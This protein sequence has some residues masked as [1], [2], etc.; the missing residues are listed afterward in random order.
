MNDLKIRLLVLKAVILLAAM[1]VLVVASS[2]V[3]FAVTPFTITSGGVGYYNI[4]LCDNAT[5]VE[6][7][8]ANELQTYIY[9]VTGVTLA[10]VGESGAQD[11]S[12]MVG[13]TAF[14]IANG[15]NPTGSEQWAIKNVGNKIIVTGGRTRGTLYAVYHLLEDEIGVRWWNLKEEYVPNLPT[16]TISNPID[17]SGTPAFGYRC[18]FDATTDIGQNTT[19]PQKD[20]LFFVRNRLNGGFGEIPAEYGGSVSFGL[21]S[22]VHTMG[23][24]LPPEQYYASHPEYYALVDGERRRNGQLCL[25]NSNVKSLIIQKTLD[26]IAASYADADSKGLPRPT[27]FSITPNDAQGLCQSP[28]CLAQRNSYGDSG[29]ILNFV[30]DVAQAVEATYPEVKIDTLAYWYFIDPPTGGVTPRSNVQIRYANVGRDIIHPL[31]HINNTS[32]RSKLESWRSITS[33]DLIFWDYAVN[34]NPNPPMPTMYNKKQDYQYLRSIGVNGVFEEQEGTTVNDMQDMKVWME[35]KLMENPNLDTNTLITD[36]T[37]KYYGA[38]GSYIRD[39]LNATKLLTDLTGNSVTFGSGYEKYDYFNLDYVNVQVLSLNNAAAAVANDPVLLQRVNMVRTSLDRL[40]LVRWNNLYN[41]AQASQKTM[42]FSKD[43]SATRLINTL[44]NQKVL[45]SMFNPGE[46][47]EQSYTDKS[48]D[49]QIS[50]MLIP[51]D[52][53]VPYNNM[54]D[55]PSEKFDLY[56]VYGGL[57]NITESN[58]LPGIRVMLPDITDQ[59]FRDQHKPPIEIGLYNPTDGARLLRNL[60]LSDIVPN[61]YTLYTITSAQVKQSDYLY[62]FRSWSVQAD[63]NAFLQGKPAQTYNVNIS[64]MFKGPSF[65][66]SAQEPDSVYINRMYIVGNTDGITV[67]IPTEN[68]RLVNNYRGLTSDKGRYSLLGHAARIKLLD[69]TD[70]TFRDQHKPLIDIGLY[71]STDGTRLLQQLALTDIVPNQYKL[72]KID[73]APV[74]QNDY[75]YLFRSWSVKVHF[76][77]FLQGK[78]AQL[79]DIYVSMKFEGPSY[80]G[81]TQDPDSVYIDRVILVGKGVLPSELSIIPS[82]GITDFSPESFYI[83]TGYSAIWQIEQLSSNVGRSVKVGFTS[84]LSEAD[85]NLHLPPVPLGLYNPTDGT[86]LLRQIALSDI[87]LNQYKLYNVANVQIKAN[88]YLY[89]FNSWAIHVPVDTARS[90]DPDQLYDIYVSM[91]FE[92]PAFGGDTTKKDAVYVDRVVAVRHTLMKYETESLTVNSISPG[93][94]HTVTA[95]SNMSGGYGDKL[96][97]YATNDYI[98]YSVPVNEIGTYNIKVSANISTDAGKFQLVIDGTNQGTE[99]DT[100]S[101]IYGYAQYDLGN[102]TFTTTGNKLFR[103]TMTGKNASSSGYKLFTDYIKLIKQ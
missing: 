54:V 38:A 43:T 103:F 6:Q 72:Y 24:M 79:Y 18:I 76:D 91:K 67:E 88:D 32:V 71:N 26:N 83:Y 101:S 40:I 80:G 10:I 62:L 89:L 30:N 95:D 42:N 55:I 35:A 19:G 85:R 20:N 36:F 47:V 48:T 23:L 3:V 73:S 33:N 70:I 14:A 92:G 28:D 51:S 34:Y 77:T 13:P 15:V 86:R 4:V 12:F 65:G 82:T 41:E 21:P 63:F 97:A 64:M 102:V 50:K 39:Y 27:M 61:Q 60:T 46:L 44:K 68:F 69:M 74:K 16:L 11:K 81:S 87:T 53:K 93:I 96:N 25:T 2:A 99:Q 59:A 37:D 7:T 94:S 58:Y 98:E 52:I 1:L 49:D 90:G 57:T 17:K 31:M 56:N 5:T 8:A 22:H 45:R 29:Y 84:M 100:Y 78:P 66:G 75:L 9:K